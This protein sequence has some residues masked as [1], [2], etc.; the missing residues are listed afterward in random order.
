MKTIRLGKIA[1]VELSNVDK[2]SKDGEK[3]VKLCNFVDVYHYW[4]I[5]S[6]LESELMIATANQ[7]Q[8]ARFSI[9]KGQVAIT[10]DSETRD[11]IGV[12]TY[13][14][15]DIKDCVLGYHCA[16][17]IPNEEELYGSYLNALLHTDYAKKFFAFNASGSGQ[18]YTLTKEI[19]EDFPV[20]LPDTIFEQKI[21]ASIF[22]NIDR[23]IGINNSICSDLES[24]AKQ[25]Y[26]YW[27]VQFDFPDENG[28]PYKSSD[29]KMVWNKALQRDIPVNWNNGTVDDFGEIVGGG[30]PST[31]NSEYYSEHG[32]AW[33]TPKDLSDHP[34]RFFTHGERDISEQGLKNSSAVLMPEGAV[35]MTSRAPIGYLAI[36]K[37][38]VT[39]NQGF[40]SI[41]PK[42]K[43]GADF[44]YYSLDLIMPYIKR[45][46]V[47]S[48]F[49][50]I[51]KS[52]LEKIP[53]ILPDGNIM[54]LF[55]EK[56]Q[57]LSEMI[58]E[59]EEENKELVSFRD[60]LLPLLMNGQVK[61]ASKKE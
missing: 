3:P 50:E 61:I 25:I 9:K 16:L 31:S 35:L 48:T 13:I 18:R 56:I 10:K 42:E 5:K 46:G 27:F 51:S 8:I 26:D 52:D 54:R 19:I 30:T 11:D 20:V 6:E 43:Y 40:K 2:K 53:V 14:A 57:P 60:F 4:Q 22:E 36:A 55:K 24:I 33:A 38:E 17:I 39:T 12:S 1:T 47:G 49:A 37:N 34:N 21:L 41:I 28:K 45:Y 15:D 29:G 32:I 44:V 58:Y 59:L 7:N 23:K